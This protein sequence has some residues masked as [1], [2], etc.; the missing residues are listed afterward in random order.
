VARSA[1]ERREALARGGGDLRRQVRLREQLLVGGRG[2]V[3]L[4]ERGERARGGEEAPPPARRL[5]REVGRRQRVLR[6]RELVALAGV[7]VGDR[8]RR[9]DGVGALRAAEDEPERGPRV[10]PPLFLAQQAR[11]PQERAPAPRARLGEARGVR[12]RLERPRAVPRDVARARQ[13]D[14]RAPGL[15]TGRRG[16]EEL[17]EGLPCLVRPAGLGLGFG[18]PDP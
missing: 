8:E 9:L 7:G 2:G 10:V 11:A 6:G 12:V 18:E 4:L 15:R 1:A 5:G 13:R 16:G 3:L 14:P 17:L